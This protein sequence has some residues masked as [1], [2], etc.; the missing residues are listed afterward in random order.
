MPSP[1]FCL[2]L[3]CLIEQ[4]DPPP[5][6]SNRPFRGP[7]L[8]DPLRLHITPSCTACPGR[9]LRRYVLLRAA[10]E[11]LPRHAG[12]AGIAVGEGWPPAAILGG[13]SPGWEVVNIPFV[14]PIRLRS[15]PMTETDRTTEV[16]TTRH[17]S[18]S[19]RRAAPELQTPP[20]VGIH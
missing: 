16:S 19:S 4:N 3:F 17:A 6:F 9:A 12:G 11:E 13:V 20:P 1:Y 14:C 18:A 8:R 15:F 10:Q 2:I 7:R 5:A